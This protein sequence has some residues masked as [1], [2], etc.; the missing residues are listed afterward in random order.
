MSDAFMKIS[1][2]SRGENFKRIFW[3]GIFEVG[4][5]TGLGFYGIAC[6]IAANFTF[7]KNEKVNKKIRFSGSWLISQKLS[8][9]RMASVLNPKNI[10]K[11]DKKVDSNKKEF[12]YGTLSSK[13]ALP[14]LE[15]AEELSKDKIT[16]DK[17][18]KDNKAF[19]KKHL[20]SRVLFGLS[21][22][23]SIITRIADFFIFGIIGSMLAL[24][25][26]AKYEKINEF[27]IKNIGLLGG[28][29]F[30]VCVGVGG[31][32]NPKIIHD[33]DL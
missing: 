22:L 18:S 31:F 28:I 19:L 26:C 11:L 16:K 24:I 3:L 33:A 4:I 14:I 20:V 10:S 12:L 6:S 9:L 17:T 7:G 2:S 5:A 8:F 1:D 21:V 30:N 23:V 25:T 32:I 13:L 27:A 15:K 29:V